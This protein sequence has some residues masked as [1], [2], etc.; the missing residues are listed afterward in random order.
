LPPPRRDLARAAADIKEFGLC[1]VEGVLQGEKLARVREGLYRAA[2]DD[3]ERSW[4]QKFAFDYAHDDTNQRVWNL[5]S[6][7]PVFTREER[8]P[9]V[10]IPGLET[11]PASGV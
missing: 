8:P 7:D 3:R 2:A 11:L 6:R 9:P 5:V 4:E 1:L 10:I